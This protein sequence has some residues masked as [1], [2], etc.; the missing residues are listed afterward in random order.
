MRD[1]DKNYSASDYL[2]G[3]VDPFGLDDPYASGDLMKYMTPSTGIGNLYKPTNKLP[4]EK[5]KTNVVQSKLNR[6]KRIVEKH[7]NET[8]L[9]IQKDRVKSERAYNLF[10]ES[11]T[12]DNKIKRLRVQGQEPKYEDLKKFHDLSMEM[13]KLND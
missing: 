4:T 10:Q 5:K 9:A 2:L 11:R 6:A 13:E 8:R 3:K 1:N 7:D 12:L